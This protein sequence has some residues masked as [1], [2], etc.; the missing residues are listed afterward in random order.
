MT[1]VPDTSLIFKPATSTP[2][3]LHT[4]RRGPSAGH[5]PR[6]VSGRGPRRLLRSPVTSVAPSPSPASSCPPL[7]ADLSSRPWAQRSRQPQPAAPRKPKAPNGTLLLLPPGAL[8]SPA[9]PVSQK[10]REGVRPWRLPATC[11]SEAC[12]GLKT[13]MEA[14]ELFG[15]C[16]DS[17]ERWLAGAPGC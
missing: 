2:G 14:A 7:P 6:R 8:G 11:V 4:P 12:W 16:G 9:P 3:A 10:R 15:R 5:G 13:A 1:S 17:M